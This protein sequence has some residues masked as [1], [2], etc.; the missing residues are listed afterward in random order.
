MCW[1]RVEKMEGHQ[2]ELD[3]DLLKYL[4]NLLEPACV[5][6]TTCNYDVIDIYF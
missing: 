4:I 1:N 3:P 5:R 6:C 2:L